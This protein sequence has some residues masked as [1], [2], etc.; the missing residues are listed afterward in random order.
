M[1][2]SLIFINLFIFYLFNNSL[3]F[4]E[5]KSKNGFYSNNDASLFNGDE[6]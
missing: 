1:A 2:V 3:N 5:A 4:F 6:V